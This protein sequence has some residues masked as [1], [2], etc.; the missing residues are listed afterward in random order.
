MRHERRHRL[1]NDCRLKPP[2]CLHRSWNLIVYAN[3]CSRK[4]YAD[5]TDNTWNVTYKLWCPLIWIRALYYPFSYRATR[6]KE[7][8]LVS[9]QLH[10]SR[11]REET[12]EN[13]D[14]RNRNATR[15]MNSCIAIEDRREIDEM[16]ICCQR[17]NN[18]NNNNNDD[19]KMSCI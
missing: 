19:D 15:I 12:S 13:V 18:N 17:N 1:Q 6:F 16:C 9:L 3:V 8:T 4:C 2:Y 14:K 10:P 11:A 5:T 7:I